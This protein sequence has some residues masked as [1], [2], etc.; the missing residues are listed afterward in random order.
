VIYKKRTLDQADQFTES[1]IP[2]MTQVALQHSTVN[3]VQS[4]PDFSCPSSLKQAAYDA[5]VENI[6]H[7]AITWGDRP[8]RHTIAPK[9]SGYLGLEADPERQI[10]VT[11]GSTKSMAATMLATIAPGDEVPDIYHNRVS[12]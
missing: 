5:I 10:T 2:E 6:N 12:Q 4:F 7:Y 1:V 3:L 9:V 8:F 11:W